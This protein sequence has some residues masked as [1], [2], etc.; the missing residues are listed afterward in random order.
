MAK[1][2]PVLFR[3]SLYAFRGGFLIRPFVIALTLGA[4]GA[5]LSSLEEQTPAIG[6]FVP[7]VL[8]PSHADPQVAQAIL[9]DIALSLIHI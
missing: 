7:E 1:S 5:V 8:F 3:S 6:S 2:L 9:T 4:A